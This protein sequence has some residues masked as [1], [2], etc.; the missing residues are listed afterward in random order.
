MSDSNSI[1]VDNL[2]GPTA[3]LDAVVWQP[4]REGIEIH[5]LY[6]DLKTG[7]AAALLRYAPGATLPVHTHTGYEHIIILRG[8]QRDAN[9]N[10]PA[11]S[12]AIN[13]P[14]SSHGVSSEQ[15]CVALA[16]WQSPVRFE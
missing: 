9:G 10:W 5:I 12:A 16:I 4:F 11:G 8:A 13:A 2:F 3:N 15:G 7:P 6:G 1:R 14:G